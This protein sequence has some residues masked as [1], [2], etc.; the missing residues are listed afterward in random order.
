MQYIVTK[1]IAV[2]A[3]DPED[4]VVKAKT[5]G[6]VMALSVNLRPQP[7]Q[8]PAAPGQAAINRVKEK[9]GK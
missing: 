3:E 5:E 7:P 4:A 8:G 1:Q 6:K 9:Q 2:D